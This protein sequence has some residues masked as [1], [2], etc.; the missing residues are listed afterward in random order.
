MPKLPPLT[1]LRA[2]EAAARQLSFKHAA[3]ELGVTP[4]AVSHQ[5]KL[6]ERYC[7][8]QLFRRRPRPLALTPAGQLLFPAVR[9]GFEIFAEALAKV[10]VGTTRG[11]L[12]VTTTNAFATRWLVPRLPGWRA[13]HPRL[14]LD[15]VGT[16]AV[17]DLGSGE[18]DI[19]I[20]Y[21]R[22]PPPGF[23][24]VE[25]VRDSFYVVASPKL[26]GAARTPLPPAKLAEFPLIETEWLPNDD[27]APRWR[28]WRAHLTRARAATRPRNFTARATEAVSCPIGCFAWAEARCEVP[29]PSGSEPR[30]SPSSSQ[31]AGPGGVTLSSAGIP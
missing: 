27:E 13:R 18:A 14:K 25:L 20:R 10:H 1:E 23:V 16:D 6:L 8:Q 11:M 9:A 21:A 5:I 29:V 28:H 24:S 2:F 26:L 19:A 22:K 30:R 4:T 15:I 12:R 3:A 31:A 7:G 17:L